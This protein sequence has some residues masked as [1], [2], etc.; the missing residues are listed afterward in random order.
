VIDSK[1]SKQLIG[2]FEKEREIK[3]FEKDFIKN[4]PKSERG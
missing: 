4:L 1:L 2:F 3:Q